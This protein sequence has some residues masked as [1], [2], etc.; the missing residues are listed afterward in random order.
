MVDTSKNKCPVCLNEAHTPLGEKNN[1][2]LFRC[3]N[4]QTIFAEHSTIVE[5]NKDEVTELYDHYYDFAQ[6][7]L[8]PATEFSLQKMV[9]SFNKFRETGKLVDI[10][11]GEGS[12]LSIAEKNSWKCFGTEVS[13]QSLKYGTEKGWIVSDN[14]LNDEKFEKNSFDVV[15]MIELIEHVPNPHIFL[16]TAFSLLRPGGLLFITT[17]NTGSLNQRWLG[18]KWSIISPPEHITI[19]SPTGMKNALKRNGFVVKKF[20]TEGFNPI[21]ILQQSSSLAKA[22]TENVSRN[23]AA[24]ALN[25]AFT[26]NSWKR[27]IKTSINQGLSLFKLGDT[28]K[29][30]AIKNNTINVNKN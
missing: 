19:W 6:F 20:K 24:F 28:L 4:C 12:L 15:T 17:P 10:G 7:K 13:P 18:T 8:S 23:D 16:E 5:K 3:K 1:F 14:A 26:N 30:W 2:A 29:V 11:F 21:E 22:K 25:E 27:M 9:L